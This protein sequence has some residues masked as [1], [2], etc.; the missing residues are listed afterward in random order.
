MSW[1]KVTHCLWSKW[2]FPLA[3]LKFFCKNISLDKT[4]ELVY[5][6]LCG[7]AACNAARSQEYGVLLGTLWQLF[8]NFV[9]GNYPLQLRSLVLWSK[10]KQKSE[11]GT[12]N[13]SKD[14][15]QR[16][17]GRRQAERGTTEFG[18]I[19]INTTYQTSDIDHYF[20]RIFSTSL[21]TVQT[22]QDPRSQLTANSCRIRVP[23]EN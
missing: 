11:M 12:Q 2:V 4:V 9:S 20:L 3:L 13:S 5:F 21:V 17:R 8:H 15:R 16:Q 10:R 6:L 1:R 14:T 19:I 18:E 23:S 7:N 22:L